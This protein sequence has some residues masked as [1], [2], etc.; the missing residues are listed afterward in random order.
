VQ[1]SWFF[2]VDINKVR[3]QIGFSSRDV[4]IAATMD[5]VG[6]QWSKGFKRWPWFSEEQEGERPKGRQGREKDERK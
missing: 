4:A 3:W 2:V 1:T 6:G 5:V